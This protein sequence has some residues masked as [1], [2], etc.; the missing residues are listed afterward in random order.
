MRVYLHWLL[1]FSPLLALTLILPRG[2]HNRLVFAK[3][4]LLCAV[5]V[6]ACYPWLI[7]LEFGATLMQAPRPGNHLRFERVREDWRRF[8]DGAAWWFG[9]PLVVVAGLN[10]IGVIN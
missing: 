1:D 4:I 2:W 6:L 8:A 3:I 5:F 9:I 7:W 10:R